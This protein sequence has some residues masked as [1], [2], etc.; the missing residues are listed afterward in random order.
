MWYKTASHRG[1][2]EKQYNHS[3]HEQMNAWKNGWM[4][5][6]PFYLLTSYR[7]AMSW[8]V[9]YCWGATLYSDFLQCYRENEIFRTI[10][11][12]VFHTKPYFQTMTMRG[13]LVILLFLFSH[14][15]ILNINH[16]EKRAVIWTKCELLLK[17]ATP[18]RTQRLKF[19]AIQS[20]SLSAQP[21]CRKTLALLCRIQPLLF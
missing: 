6:I 10:L 5:R 8:R 15:P 2:A 20:L 13:C 4:C 9:T 16:A 21:G 19:M 18:L 12:S 14:T 11:Y 3:I 1:D 7:L 17:L